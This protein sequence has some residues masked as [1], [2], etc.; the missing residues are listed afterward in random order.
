MARTSIARMAIVSGPHAKDTLAQEESLAEP[1]ALP[2]A[3]I[4]HLEKLGTAIAGLARQ[5]ERCEHTPS[6]T[7]ERI[8]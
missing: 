3:I 1:H 7:D 6:I 2:L 5:C 4:D 8:S